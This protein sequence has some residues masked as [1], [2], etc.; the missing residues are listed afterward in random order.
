[1]NCSYRENILTCTQLFHGQ[2]LSIFKTLVVTFL[3]V[4]SLDILTPNPWTEVLLID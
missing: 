4:S 1:M 2:S 3:H